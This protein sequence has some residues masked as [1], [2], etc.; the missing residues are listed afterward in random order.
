[1]S[2]ILFRCDSVYQLMNAIQIKISFLQDQKADLLLSDHTNFDALIPFIKES[3][4]FSEV[5]RLFSKQKADEYWTYSKKERKEISLHPQEYID[6]EFLDKEYTDFYISFDTAYA[7][8]MYYAMVQKGM[9]PRV[10]LFED[11]MA[12]YVCDVKQRCMEDGMDHE[13][14]KEEQFINQIDRLLLY[15]PD[16]FTGNLMPFPIKKI[17]KI[18]YKEPK[19]VKLFHDIFGQTKMPKEK[20][21]FL[22]EAFVD[23]KIPSNDLELLLS[24]AELVGKDQ[25]IIKLH[26]RNKIN[27][28]EKYGLKTMKQTQVPW[29]IML[30]DHEITDKVLFT[31]SSNASIT[32]K[33]IFEKNMN[34]IMLYRTFFGKTWLMGNANFKEYHERSIKEFNKDRKN[35]YCPNSMDEIKEILK[36]IEGVGK[37]EARS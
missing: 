7:K 21:I 14:Y 13:A 29:E 37:I 35:I 28:F 27:R 30:M 19:I 33:L 22:E 4:V 11:G 23:D 5:K 10:H 32:S 9:H 18:Q 6:T 12:T 15:E 36:Y 17:P 2:M 25:M 31:I 20:Y 24:I 34:L 16:L 8:L 3:Q 1:M 26:P